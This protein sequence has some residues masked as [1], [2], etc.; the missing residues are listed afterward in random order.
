MLG[1]NLS[2]IR[3]KVQHPGSEDGI[4]LKKM[5]TP[6]LAEQASSFFQSVGESLRL[7]LNILY[8][9]KEAPRNMRSIL[10][11]MAHIGVDT[12]PIASLMAFFVGMV[13]ALHSGYQLS[14]FG[15]QVMI[16]RLV[17]ISM[18]R[19]LGPVLT[20]LLLAGRV[21]SAMAAEIGTMKVSDELDALRTL[22]ISPVRYLAMPRFLAS[23]VMLPLLVLY[24]DIVGIVGG[25]LTA[26][27]YV[28]LAPSVYFNNLFQVLTFSDIFEGLIKAVFF[29]AVVALVGCYQGLKTTGGA[30]GVGRATTSSVVI[31]FLLIMILDYIVTRFLV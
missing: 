29:G 26:A 21:G 14:K 10:K 28:R 24:A 30:R 25:A 18:L 1:F 7:L 27:T 9:C 19:E 3:A 20:G 8:W 11:Q 4:K 17:G 2:E 13:L 31:S 15:A 22:R 6:T 23:L 12:L 16:G 5:G